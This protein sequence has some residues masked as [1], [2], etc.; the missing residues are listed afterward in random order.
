MDINWLRD[1]VCLGRTLNFTRAAEELGLSRVGLRNKLE[2]YEL[3]QI[4]QKPQ[5]AQG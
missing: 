4:P 2:R 5:T 1:F 3:E